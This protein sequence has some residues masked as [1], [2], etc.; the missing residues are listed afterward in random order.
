MLQSLTGDET[1]YRALLIKLSE[2]L[3]IFYRRRLKHLPV[4][5]EDLVQEALLAIHN[6]RHT[7]DPAQPFTAWAY[8]IARYKL[9][10]L[11]RRRGRRELLTDALDDSND[12]LVASD[13]DASEARRDLNQLLATLPPRQRDAIVHVKIDGRSVAETAGLTGTS[14]S[15]VK[16]SIHRGLKTLAKRMREWS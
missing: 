1:A 2:H 8:A 11:L 4:E 13:A 9:V 14:E 16:V 12:L 10:D 5:V 7:Y 6:Q 15:A 3:R